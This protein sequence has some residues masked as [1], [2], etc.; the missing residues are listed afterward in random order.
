MAFKPGRSGNPN[1]RPK[2]ITLKKS[3]LKRMLPRLRKHTPEAI[4]IAAA[5]MKMED[6]S[7]KDRMTAVKFI[8]DTYLTALIKGVEHERMLNDRKPEGD[9]NDDEGEEEMDVGGAVLSFSVVKKD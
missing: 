2:K 5:I 9:P 6:A 1:G 4:E 8:T 3:E 7:L